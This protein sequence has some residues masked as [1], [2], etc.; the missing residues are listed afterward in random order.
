[1]FSHVMVGTNDLEAS[2]DFY[3]AVLGTLGIPPGML[4]NGTRYFYRSPKGSFSITK[5]ID[6]QAATHANG[7]TIGFLAETPEQVQAFHAAGIAN[8][9]TSCEEPP[10]PREGP[11][12]ALY[13]AYLRDPSGNKICALHRPTKPA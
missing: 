1:M 13:L 4:N 8:G 9:G 3:D 5:P 12:G 7:G 6:G 2:K 11:F 10:G